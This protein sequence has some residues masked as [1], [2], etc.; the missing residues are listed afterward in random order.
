MSTRKRK[1]PDLSTDD[2]NSDVGAKRHEPEA[3]PV[4]SSFSSAELAQT[5]RDFE[6]WSMMMKLSEET[7]EIAT[8][9]L[10]ITQIRCAELSV[11]M[12]EQLFGARGSGVAI[13]V[14]PA[15]GK[16][17]KLFAPPSATIEELKQLLW[18]HDGTPV[19]QQQLIFAGKQLSN[20]ETLAACGIKRTMMLYLVL[21]SRA[22]ES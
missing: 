16:T 22:V 17:I 12:S 4:L 9:S 3:P 13:F 11:R 15:T 14:K 6:E 8:N 20:G 1:L 7:I 21:R 19:D 18:L 10:R 5:R 2:E